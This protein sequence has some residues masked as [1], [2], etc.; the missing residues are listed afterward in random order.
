MKTVKA[1]GNNSPV[2]LREQPGGKILALIPQGAQAEVIRT[3]ASWSEVIING[4]QTG[5]MMSKFLIDT[6]SKDLSALKAKL[7]EILQMLDELED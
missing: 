3:Q 2:R 1:N 5:W 7:K 6:A 4:E